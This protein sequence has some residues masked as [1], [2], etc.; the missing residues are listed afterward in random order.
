MGIGQGAIAA[1]PSAVLPMHISEP[2]P[3][4]QLLPQVVPSSSL[5]LVAHQ[6]PVAPLSAVIRQLPAMPTAPVSDITRDGQAPTPML[7]IKTR[8]ELRAWKW[9]RKRDGGKDRR[10]RLKYG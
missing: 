6:M 1:G 10:Y 8:K 9:R 4:P 2:K 5:F 3:A 7:A